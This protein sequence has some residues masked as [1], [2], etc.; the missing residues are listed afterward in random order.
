MNI[1]CIEAPGSPVSIWIVRSIS[2][3]IK[4]WF[5][6]HTRTQNNAHLLRHGMTMFIFCCSGF[7]CLLFLLLFK[8]YKLSLITLKL[9]LYM[10]KM[11]YI[12]LYVQLRARS[13]YDYLFIV[14]WGGGVGV[15]F[16]W[17]GSIILK[18]W[19]IYF[20]LTN[21]LFVKDISFLDKWAA[22]V[23]F[24]L[25]LKKY[26]CLRTKSFLISDRSRFFLNSSFDKVINNCNVFVQT[27]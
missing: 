26:V 1:T 20:V 27:K 8:K 12:E 14:I 15:V 22:C 24:D 23:Y 16:F 19:V 4:K 13:L 10:L 2:V 21:Q 9:V 25:S 17:G 18:E 11:L 3:H 6:L 7:C 5:K